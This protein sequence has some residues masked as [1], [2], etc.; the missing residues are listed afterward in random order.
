M[1][2]ARAQKGGKGEDF[3]SDVEK[4][5]P[6][7]CRDGVKWIIHGIIHPFRKARWP[8]SMAKH[9]DFL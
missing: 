3:K 5:T 2:V 4:K 6:F 1:H 9:M 7:H 8:A